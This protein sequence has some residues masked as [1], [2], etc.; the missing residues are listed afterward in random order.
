MAYA[1]GP[2]REGDVDAGVVS[3]GR[4]GRG[5]VVDDADRQ[6]D[7]VRW[8]RRAVVLRSAARAGWWKRGRAKPRRRRTRCA[9]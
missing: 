9:C 1:R 8:R 7:S 2:G 4:D 6:A 3:V 5:L